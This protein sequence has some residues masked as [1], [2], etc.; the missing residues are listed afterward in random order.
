MRKIRE[1]GQGHS[2]GI[3][4]TFSGCCLIFII[5][6]VA[7]QRSNVVVEHNVAIYRQLS[8]GDWVMSSDE[9]PSLVFRP[10]PDDKM[11]GVDVNGL[12]T[13]AIG[14][15]ADEA[16]WEERG[17]CK[18]ILRADLGF[19]FRDKHNNFTYRKVN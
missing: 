16:R 17:T 7:A 3:A 14:Y 2:L 9:E 1:K 18:S 8:D 15:V 12:L 4:Y 10:C 5:L 6:G 13:Q 19:W 11:G